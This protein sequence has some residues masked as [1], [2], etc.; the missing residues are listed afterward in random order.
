MSVYLVLLNFFY[1][2]DFYES[3]LQISHKSTKTLEFDNLDDCKYISHCEGIL[4]FFKD[5][6]LYNCWHYI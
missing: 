2:I 1:E 6:L 3:S 4:E 5:D